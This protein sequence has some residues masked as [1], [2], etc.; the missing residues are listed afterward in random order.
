MARPLIQMA[1]DVLSLDAISKPSTVMEI[2]NPSQDYLDMPIV[3]KH[4]KIPIP[5]PC[6]NMYRTKRGKWIN[7]K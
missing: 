3:I 6:K 2:C 7:C 5:K 4:T 1:L